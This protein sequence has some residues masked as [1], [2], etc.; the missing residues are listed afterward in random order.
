MKTVPLIKPTLPDF[1]LFMQQA[2]SIWDTHILS[3]QGPLVQELES[4][5]S[6]YLKTDHVSTFTNGHIALDCAI[7]AFDF[8]GGEVI[9][10]P[11]TFVSTTQ[12]IIA[13]GLTPVFCDIKESDCTIDE[14]KIEAL[15]TEK[16]KAIIPVHVYGFP[17]NHQKIQEIA[18]KHNL[19]VI[20]DSAHGFGVTVDGKGIG[21]LGDLSMFS[22]HATKIFH[23]VEGG[24]LSFSDKNLGNKLTEIRNFGLTETGDVESVATNGKMSEIHAAMGLCNL[25]MIDDTISKRKKIIEYYLK[26]LKNVDGITCFL[27]DKQNI[28]YNYAYFPVLFSNSCQDKRNEIELALKE[29]YGILTRRYFSPMTSDFTLFRAKYP[30]NETPIAKDIANRVLTLPL[31]TDLTEED[32]DYVCDCLNQITTQIRS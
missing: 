28:S 15:I 14:D 30:C 20:Y 25:K 2:K 21:S 10:T 18:D 24:C 26:K 29:K 32:I 27:W 8:G 11:Y 16:T 22:F 3:N 13:N 23:T 7:K 17:C 6:D 4:N 31:Y 9:T 12:T 1:D 5:L 19:K